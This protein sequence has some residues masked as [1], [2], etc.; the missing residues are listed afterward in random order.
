MS[1]IYPIVMFK[2][3][4]GGL[5]EG[6]IWV[7]ATCYPEELPLACM[8]DD[9]LCAD[10]FEFLELNEWECGVNLFGETIKWASGRTPEETISKLEKT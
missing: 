10:F 4:Y 8:G 3:R 7:A 1:N 2:A 9:T 6:G 5:Y